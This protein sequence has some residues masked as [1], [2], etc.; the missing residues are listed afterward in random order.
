MKNILINAVVSALVAAV[1]ALGVG[2]LVG[3]QSADL[4]AS[5]TRFPNGLSADST[6]PSAGQVRGTT[7]TFTSTANIT[8]NATFSSG[9]QVDRLAF[10]GTNYLAFSTTTDWTITAAQACDTRVIDFTPSAIGGVLV[11]LPSAS[12]MVADCLPAIG[13]MKILYFRNAGNAAASSTRWLAG[14]SSTVALAN[15]TSTVAFGTTTL[16]GGDSGMF[17]II[18]ATSSDAA[19]NKVEWNIVQFK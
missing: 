6:S 18:Y 7:L 16:A 17:T 4:G 19:A 9:V 10:G 5:G 13:D 14:A 15:P 11:T 8:G 2:G 3:N 1:V 12:S